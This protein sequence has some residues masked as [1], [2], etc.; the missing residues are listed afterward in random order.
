MAIQRMD[1]LG[2]VVDDLDAAVAFFTE[3]GLELEG[4]WP[5]EGPWVGRVIGLDG[6]RSDNA[7]LATP[8][9]RS[10]VELSQFSSPSSPET[11]G[12]PPANALGI[13]HICFAVD[14]VDD[15]LARLRPHGAEL[16]GEVERYEDLY[17]LCYVRGPAGIIVELA[18]EL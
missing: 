8:D 6:V 14:D 4:T 9:G 17:R 12:R 10:R 18:Q 11:E 13:R 16:I 15:S 5:V 7:M 3:L 1:H 2:I